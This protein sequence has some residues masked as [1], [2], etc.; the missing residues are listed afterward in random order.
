MRPPSHLCRNLG[1]EIS[2]ALSPLLLI[3][4]GRRPVLSAECVSSDAPA[5]DRCNDAGRVRGM[6]VPQVTH[7]S[8]RQNW[9]WLQDF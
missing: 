8:D 4:I 1:T 9:M 5:T 3:F 2:G 6:T 7:P